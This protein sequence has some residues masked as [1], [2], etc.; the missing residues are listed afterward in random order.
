M[1]VIVQEPIISDFIVVEPDE[2]QGPDRVPFSRILQT[3]IDARQYKV[4][5]A[6]YPSMT[7]ARDLLHE[8]KGLSAQARKRSERRVEDG[9]FEF[10]QVWVLSGHFEEPLL[11]EMRHFPDRRIKNLIDRPRKPKKLENIAS[12]G[13]EDIVDLSRALLNLEVE[14]YTLQTAIETLATW[15]DKKEALF[16]PFAEQV[17][18]FWFL[19]PQYS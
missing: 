17:S 8:A 13:S 15:K 4:L 12:M 18:T 19:T 2:I 14:N 3:V 10:M 7:T 6:L 11:E 16:V 9:V 5:A 1:K